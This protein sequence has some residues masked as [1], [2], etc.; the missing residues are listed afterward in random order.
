[1]N[2]AVTGSNGY[3]GKYICDQFLKDGHQVIKFQ[4]KVIDKDSVKYDLR[5]EPNYNFENTDVFIHCAYD[6]NLK[7]KDQ[8]RKFNIENSIKIINLAIDYGVKNIFFISSLSSFPKA[9]SIYGQSKFKIE[10]NIKLKNVNILRPGLL[11]D[12]EIGGIAL[13]IKKI[14]NV[15]PLVFYPN[16]SKKL[17]LCEREMVFKVIDKIIS[18]KLEITDPITIANETPYSMLDF[19]KFLSSSNKKKFVIFIPAPVKFFLI[20]FKIIKF[21][22]INLRVNEDNL[23]SFINSYQK[24]DL[25]LFNDILS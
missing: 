15:F 11:I 14:L 21:F 16:S 8:I 20:L 17:F 13:S 6:F 24:P 7:T 12:E 22:K 19:L 10:E 5:E 23:I 18:N 4:K 9:Q 3:L 25:K 1:M 2:I